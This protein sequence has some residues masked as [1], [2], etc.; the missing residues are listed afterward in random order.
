MVEAGQL[1]S[2]L[3]RFQQREAVVVSVA[4]HARLSVVCLDGEDNVVLILGWKEAAGRSADAAIVVL[5]PHDDDRVVALV[6]S[7][8][9]MDGLD[10]SLD[11]DIAL[12]DQTGIESLLSAVSK[13]AGA[14]AEVKST[15]GIGVATAVL[16]IALVGHDEGEG[17][18]FAGS[19]VSIEAG[20]TSEADDVVQTIVGDGSIGR[21]G[22]RRMDCA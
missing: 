7:R 21:S 20:G 19:E 17:R 8:R 18:G 3:D 5:V 14:N 2:C 10:Y 6:P 16:V 9:S 4:L 13:T 1:K 12:E 11:R 22:S 15:E